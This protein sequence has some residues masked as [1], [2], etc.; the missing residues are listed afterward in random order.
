MI[1]IFRIIFIL[2]LIILI[3]NCV[4]EPPVSIT[5]FAAIGGTVKDSQEN[6]LEGVKINTNEKESYSDDKGY[7]VINNISP[8]NHTIFASKDNYLQSTK[9]VEVVNKQMSK[10]DFL[11]IKYDEIPPDM[12]YVQ[13]G[14]FQMGDTFGDG[15]SDERPV[16]DVT[17]DDFYIS[18][19]EVSN[20]QY[21]EFLNSEGNQTEGGVTWLDINDSD[22]RIEYTGGEYIQKNGY[23]DHPVVEVTW[24]GARAYCEWIGGR[25]PT[26]A[27]WEYAARGGIESNGYKYSGSNNIEDV[28][29]YSGNSG[30]TTN[31][32]GEKYP[33][34][35]GIKDMSGNV[36]EWCNDW[37]DEDYYDISPDNNPQGPG[38]GTY[39]VLRGGSWNYFTR[40]CRVSY[41]YRYLPGYS[42]CDSGFRVAQDL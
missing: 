21:V 12:I 29:W 11:L 6:P 30:G 31:A 37:Y 13:G 22:C 40:D 38:S 18:K 32:V 19:Y 39:K 23:E 3:H 41:R 8:G 26:E 16:H 9:N 24:Y 14:S 20:E 2:S 5:E 15:D 36:L 42:D 33:N 1:R 17:K 10:A 25:L 27:E 35:L 4:E 28:A 7:F 34:E